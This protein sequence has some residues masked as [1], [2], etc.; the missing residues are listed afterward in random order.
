M[1]SKT[2]V[3][4]ILAEEENRIEEKRRECLE[5]GGNSVGRIGK[6]EI[7]R[8]SVWNIKKV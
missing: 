3:N 4:N 5:D 7:N 2:D 8:D 1:I 6:V